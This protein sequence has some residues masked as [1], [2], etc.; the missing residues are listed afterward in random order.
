M[1]Y[2]ILN[3]LIFSGVI[4]GFIFTIMSASNPGY[5]HKA[6]PFVIMTVVSLSLSNL[7]YWLIDVYDFYIPDVYYIQFELLIIPFFY[8]FL[9]RLLN[10]NNSDTYLV[11]I[12]FILAT[13]YQ[14]WSSTYHIYKYHIYVEFLTILYNIGL[15]GKILHLLHAYRKNSK[16]QEIKIRTKWIIQTTYLGIL[17]IM[18]WFFVT[19]VFR[20]R[21]ENTLKIYYP[22][23]IGI[24]FLI[25][26]MGQR[27]LIDL[28]TLNERKSIRNRN[29]NPIIV[30]S[31]TVK[32]GY[33][34][35]EKI[36]NEIKASKLYMNPNISLSDVANKFN[37]SSGYLSQLMGR[38]SEN[39]FNNMINGLR[40]DE[41]KKMLLDNEFDK[42][43]NVSIGLEAGFNS[44][45]SFF[46]VFK[47][48]TGLTPSQYR[49]RK[50]NK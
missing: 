43:T 23:W 10:K 11:F 34:T 19:L 8:N 35:F 31:M 42:Y 12:P 40:V 20:L 33:E 17:L 27:F 32:G 2:N 3:T 7:Q 39:G 24:S 46:A 1:N 49:K 14:V 16:G 26:F 21:V 38:Y 22:L 41:A 47:K 50:N 45:S 18:I 6:R 4:Y 5:R 28:K 9:T 25:Y 37:L 48:H 15:I 13:F 29:T 36:E 30:N 44:R